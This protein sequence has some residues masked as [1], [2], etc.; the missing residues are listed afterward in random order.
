M[1]RSALQVL[2]ASPSAEDLK[3]IAEGPGFGKT[4][5]S[6]SS[7]TVANRIVRSPARPYLFAPI[8]VSHLEH[9]YSGVWV[10]SFLFFLL[11]QLLLARY[12]A[13]RDRRM[14]LLNDPTFTAS[15]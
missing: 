9:L 5:N 1:K 11:R 8:D 6:T 2:R 14:L 15:T 7:S 12:T 4:V 10:S 3:T 13:Q